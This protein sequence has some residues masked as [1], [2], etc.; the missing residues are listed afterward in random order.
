M[1]QIEPLSEY[2]MNFIRAIASNVHSDFTLEKV[3]TEY[4]LGSYSN[5]T[6]LTSA[7]L[8]LDIIEKR[9]DGIFLTDPVFEK[10]FRKKMIYTNM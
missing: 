8:K 10:W 5:I 9:R 6:R 1:Q 4:H 2:Q 7:L 3:R